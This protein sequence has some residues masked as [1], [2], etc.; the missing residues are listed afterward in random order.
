MKEKFMDFEGT[1]WLEQAGEFKFEVK[2]A[3]VKDSNAGNPMVVITVQ[4]AEGQSTLYFSLSPKARWK[5]NNFIKACLKLDHISK[6]KDLEIDYETIHQSLIG[7]EFI[8]TVEAD[9]YEKKTKVPTD[10]G[11]FEEKVEEKISYKIVAFN[12][13]Q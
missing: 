8:G 6:Y 12:W 4:A 10:D 3:E 13:V 7:K 5:Y 2:E 9:V 11:R 1:Q